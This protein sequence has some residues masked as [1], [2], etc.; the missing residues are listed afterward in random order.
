VN[1]WKAKII[2]TFINR[3][4]SS[5]IGARIA[6]RNT[7]RIRSISIFPDFNT[8]APDEKESYLE[9]A[10]NMEQQGLIT[11]RWEK[12]GKGERI[13]TLTCVDIKKLFEELG[14]KDPKTKAEEIRSLFRDKAAAFNGSGDYPFLKYL[15]EQ[16][17]FSEPGRGI[18]YKAAEDFI[19]LLEVLR[20]STWPK[21]L[22]TRALSIFLYNDSKHLEYLMDLFLPVLSQVQKQG[23][24]T[25]DISFLERSFPETMISGKLVFEY[26]EDDP[27]PLIN[28][29]G[30]ILGFP[31]PSVRAMGN[32]KT[33]EAKENPT[34]L[35][36]ENKETFYA[37][38]G[39]KNN[40]QESNISRY[41]SFLYTGGY[42]NQA[43][44]AM[45]KI[46]SDSGFSLYHAGDLDPDGILILQN[47]MDV[48]GKPVS[49][50]GMD[51]AVFDRYLPFARPL[52]LTM[53][54]QIKKIRDDTKAIPGLADLIRRIEETGRGVEQE[55]VDYRSIAFASHSADS[56]SCQHH[57]T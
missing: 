11:L 9:A 48:T 53:L 31:L 15:S 21:N 49:P 43:A 3:S 16:F 10:E 18:S 40:G 38:A 17:G 7:I 57:G 54:A 35:M 50:V 5:A 20:S 12:R 46:L 23:I 6:E 30:L 39:A 25:P 56:D 34:V 52:A 22:T 29:S 36:I 45:I 33:V 19:Y 32:I 47:I 26:R 8:A 13:R 44:A 4:F 14:G 41:D 2:D 37:L 51:A 1:G 27:P 55:I 24:P 28:A 42:L